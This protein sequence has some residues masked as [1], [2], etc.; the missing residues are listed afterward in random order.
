MLILPFSRGHHA[1]GFL[2]R[3]GERLEHVRTCLTSYRY[4]NGARVLL[5]GQ[6]DHRI[7]RDN[8]GSFADRK[9]R[10]Q[11]EG[12]R[13]CRRKL[14]R[15]QV[16]EVFALVGRE[17]GKRYVVDEAVWH[18]VKFAVWREALQNVVGHDL[19]AE[20]RQ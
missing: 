16:H 8:T 2:R 3:S 5:R 10:F 9:A 4:V 11:D 1:L 17:R 15:E 20:F 6:G 12:R 18:D 7:G 14:Q 13:D 19:T